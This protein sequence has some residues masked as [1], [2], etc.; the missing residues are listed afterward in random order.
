MNVAAIIL[1]AGS[2]TRLGSSKQD[3]LL[4]EETLLERT[5]RTAHLA[6]L[7]PVLVIVAPEHPTQFRGD[8]TILIN[9]AASEGMA[10]SIRTG[11][12]AAQRDGFEGA[13][14]LAC[15]QPAVTAEH[16]SALACGGQRII[17]SS[18]AGRNGVPAYFPKSEFPTLMDLS[19]DVGARELLRLADTV[20]LK[21]GE[22]D[23]DTAEDLKR[24]RELYSSEPP[25]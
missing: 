8:I 14:I 17:A 11:I 20:D 18:Y 21:Q 19:G 4:G 12:T 22:L 1:A 5:I 16:L 13:I 23:I 24:A 15:D 9:K 2:S 10:S 25:L 6:G 7:E 3:A